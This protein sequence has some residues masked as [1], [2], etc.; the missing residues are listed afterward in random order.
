LTYPAPMV[1]HDLARKRA[2]EVYGKALKG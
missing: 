1:P 2:L